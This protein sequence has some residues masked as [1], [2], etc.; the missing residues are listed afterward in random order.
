MTVGIATPIPVRPGAVAVGRRRG[1]VAKTVRSFRSRH[2]SPKVELRAVTRHIRP[3]SL[4]VG[5][6]D[7]A[8]HVSPNVR[9]WR[10]SKYPLINRYIVDV[11]QQVDP[12]SVRRLPATRHPKRRVSFLTEGRTSSVR[13]ALDIRFQS[14]E[15]ITPYQP[16]SAIHD[17]R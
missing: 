4:A 14:F 13:T 12:S 11:R 8:G 2:R 6:L 10:Y 5:M 3:A 9:P 17:Q 16:Q 15:K 1:S 7:P